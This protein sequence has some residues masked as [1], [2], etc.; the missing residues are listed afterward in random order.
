[1]NTIVETK[2]GFV[3]IDMNIVRNIHKDSFKQAIVK[4]FV[5]L[6]ASTNI[7]I[8]AEGIE[9]KE[10]LKTLIRLGVY[11]G[12]GY[13]FQDPRAS[14]LIYQKALFPPF[15]DTISKLRITE[16]TIP[17]ITLLVP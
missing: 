12:Q 16:T 5:Q 4:S 11:A 13:Y 9:T 7:K 17:V 14:F 15:P 10:E 6:G 1:M 8:I 2:P 3:K